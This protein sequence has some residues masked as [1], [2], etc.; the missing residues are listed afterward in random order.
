MLKKRYMNEIIL[1]ATFELFGIWHF[2][3]EFACNNNA[4]TFSSG[5]E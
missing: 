3:I 5:D 4:S 1:K 2:Y